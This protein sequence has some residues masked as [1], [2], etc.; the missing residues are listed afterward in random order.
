MNRTNAW[1]WTMSRLI[2]VLTL[3]LSIS[4]NATEYIVNNELSCVA[5]PAATS[6]V[7][8][9]VSTGI[10]D[11][12]IEIGDT[13]IIRANQF[14]ISRSKTLTVH[15]TFETQ[16]YTHTTINGTLINEN[17]FQ[18]GGVS[19]GPW[20]KIINNGTFDTDR[21]TVAGGSAEFSNQIGRFPNS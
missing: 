1:M 7:G 8:V 16:P 3:F 21:L 4:A 18:S 9:G 5:L 6:W 20:G 14:F 15:G 12:V 11:G 10:E 13:W 17:E 2:F 19:F